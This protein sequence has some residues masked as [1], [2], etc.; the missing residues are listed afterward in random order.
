[1]NGGKQ[2]IDDRLLPVSAYLDNI[3]GSHGGWW[4]GFPTTK[5]ELQESL[6]DHRRP[7]R[8]RG[9]CPSLQYRPQLSG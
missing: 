1:M 3:D 4:H 7:E 9:N 8:R 2:P 6:K 5:E